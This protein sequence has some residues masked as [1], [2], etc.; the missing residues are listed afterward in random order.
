[1]LERFAGFIIA[2]SRAVLAIAALLF[3]L[4]GVCGAHVVDNLSGGGFLAPGAESAQASTILATEFGQGDSPYFIELTDPSGAMSEAAR[5]V[6][7]AL[8]AE[9]ADTRQVAGVVSPWTSPPDVAAGLLSTDGS[10]A[11][12]EASFTGGDIAGPKYAQQFTDRFVTGHSDPDGVSLTAGGMSMTESQIYAQSERDLLVMELIAIP[13]SFVVLVWIFGGLV[14]ALLPVLVGGF[15][16]VGTVAVLRGVSLLTDVS[17]F[18]LNLT[19]ATG[20]ALAVDY[21]LLIISR[22]REELARGGEELVR[23]GAVD[24]ALIRAMRTA[25]R[26]VLFSAL[27]IGLSLSVLAL[28]PQFFLRSFAYAGLP[29]VALVVLAVLVITPAFIHLL[30]GRLESLNLRALLR[31]LLHRPAPAEAPVTRQFLYR[32]TALVMRHPVRIGATVVAFLAVLAVPFF[33]LRPG[34]TDDRVLPTAL[35]ARAVGNSIR[36]DFAHDPADGLSVV[37]SG[38][39]EQNTAQLPDYAAALSRV[40]D[41]IGVSAPSGQYVAGT[42]VADPTGPTGVKGGYALLSIAS[43]DTPSSTAS[44]RQLD[45]LHR[46]SP[47]A[48]TVAQ[49]AG[50]PQTSRDIAHGVV[51]RL[52]LVLGVIAVI[53]FGLLFLLTGS[54]VLPAKALLLDLLSLT[55]AFGAMVWVFQDGHLAGLGTAATGFINVPMLVLLF[56][57][58]FG[59]SMDYEVFIMSRIHEEWSSSAR[60]RQDNDEAVRVGLAR[61]GR[62]VTAAALL[63]VVSFV[64]LGAARVANVRMLGVGLALAVLA[65][66][67]LIRMMLVPAFMKV[68]GRVNWW[69]P[70]ALQRGHARWG[71]GAPGGGG[72]APARRSPRPVHGP[73]RHALPPARRGADTAALLAG[74]QL[75]AKVF[76]PFADQHYGGSAARRRRVLNLAIW[77]SAALAAGWVVIPLVTR[78]GSWQCIAAVN[79]ITALL[80]LA[81]PLLH[82]F[83]E[84][85]APVAF[86]ATGSVCILMLCWIVGT[87]SGLQFYSLVAASLV[88]LVLGVEHLVLAGTLAAIGA[89]LAIA[90]EF[91]VPADTH[92][93]PAAELDACFVISVAVSTLMVAA[94]VSCA[95]REMRY[96]EVIAAREY[97]RSESL[98]S[99]ILPADVAQQLK[100]PSHPVI[101]DKYA[102][103]SVLFADIAGYTHLAGDIEPEELVGF[104]NSLYTG[105]DHLVDKHGLEKI[106]TSGDACMVISGVPHPRPD[107]AEALAALALD[108]AAAMAGLTDPKGRPVPLRIGLSAGPVV[109]GVVG[110]RRFFYDVWGDAVNVAARMEST[111]TE[112]R[113]QVTQAFYERLKRDFLFEERGFVEVKGK[114]VMHTWYLVGRRNGK[115][116]ARQTGVPVARESGHIVVPV[117]AG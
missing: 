14:A 26:T 35:S 84:L 40:D 96:A 90:V 28:F 55:A 89:A 33:G 3:A 70:A 69:A 2:R 58:A 77:L 41:I 7:T 106:K 86:F 32:S 50:V 83:G 94:T 71:I 19:V 112:G 61:S 13:V 101:A 11:L 85:V 114:G 10:S 92:R 39:D 110:A 66:A 23:G 30:A 44:E 53:T 67:T 17:I 12:I 105:F 51:T 5:T 109:A 42:R 103:A 49:F 93:L 102:E 97:E 115:P 65:D 43:A 104:L 75:G 80:L 72:R 45:E 60:S 95:L 29:A 99:N 56:C 24:A 1:M 34:F 74:P 63:M 46:I 20:L 82:R 54:V 31:R 38:L 48:E 68:M 107:H 116:V 76:A 108:M 8:V 73:P 64:A 81:V 22:Y 100:N 36:A 113:I 59:L 27:T 16:I 57:I 9:L 4:A 117:A 6:G 88:F 98:L 18:A 91:V 25:G 111:G 79:A 87:H 62:V 47:P 37:V 15:A 52:P 78:Q 21:T